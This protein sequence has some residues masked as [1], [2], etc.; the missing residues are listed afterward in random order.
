MCG[1]AH[2]TYFLKRALDPYFDITVIPTPRQVFMPNRDAAEIKAGDDHAKEIAK[3][4]RDFDFVNIQFEP[5]ILGR[6]MTR[7]VKRFKIMLSEVRNLCVTFHSITRADG[8]TLREQAKLLARGRVAHLVRETVTEEIRSRAW[9]DLYRFLAAK[10]KTSRVTA[11]AH[12]GRDARYV[13]LRLPSSIPVHTTPLIF[14]DPEY[15]ASIAER[16][17]TSSLRTIAPK[18]A[19]NTRYLGCFGF[20]SGYKGFETALEALRL[21][22]DNYE[23]LMFSSLH[24]STLAPDQKKDDYLDS[25]LRIVQADKG[26]SRGS[27]NQPRRP[28]SQRVHFL[29]AVNDDDLVLGMKLCDVVLLPYINSNHT[30][31]GPVAIALD[32][33]CKVIASRNVQFLELQKLRGEIFELCDI[34]NPLEYTQKIPRLTMERKER[35]V[36]GL[37]LIDYPPLPQKFTSGTT[38]SIYREAIL[39]GASHEFSA[40][41]DA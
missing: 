23:L 12:T 16:C 17:E 8:L 35:V 20:F 26:G 3:Q 38:A 33:D 37:R 39:G 27:G 10:A 11:I 41:A 2:Y 24:E 40:V 5:G 21:M 29:G 31:S 36:S 32:L 6:S 28:L 34:S 9:S 30:A 14:I 15:K 7:V 13:R 1:I 22:P 4:L 18:P 19:E 25:L